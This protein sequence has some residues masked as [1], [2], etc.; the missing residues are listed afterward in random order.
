[1][2]HVSCCTF[3]LLLYKG[4]GGVEF[5]VGSLH[6]GFGG[7]DGLGG[8]G[9]FPSFCLS[10]KIQYQEA[11]ATVLA[12]SVVV[13]V[14]VLTATPVELNPLLRHPDGISGCLGGFGASTIVRKIGHFGGP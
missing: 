8:S 11:A 5:K 14:S 10:Y 9:F 1:M 3:V 7:L 6:D 2:L 13:A 4:G 12:V